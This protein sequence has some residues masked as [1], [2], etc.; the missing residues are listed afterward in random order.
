MDKRYIY[1]NLTS[2]IETSGIHRLLICSKLGISL[3]LLNDFEN[4]RLR[5]TDEMIDK[6]YEMLLEQQSQLS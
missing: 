6:L 5:M 4:K 2:L 1:D 3:A